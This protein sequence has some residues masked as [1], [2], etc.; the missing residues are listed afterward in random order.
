MNLTASALLGLLEEAGTDVLTLAEG[1]SEDELLNS[2]ITRTEIRRLLISMA[3]TAASLPAGLR[4]R[5]PE[6]DWDGWA[7]LAVALNGSE[8]EVCDGLWH[9]VRSQVPATL[10]WLR[11]YRQNQPELF[12][13]VP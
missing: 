7:A 12:A 5:V 6:I 2:R 10:M 9:G 1:L 13:F 3:Q 4:T 11:V 8:A